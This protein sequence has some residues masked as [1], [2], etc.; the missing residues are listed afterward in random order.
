MI[1]DSSKPSASP[2]VG[3]NSG[4]LGQG[5]TLLDEPAIPDKYT[6]SDWVPA[7]GP[8]MGLLSV[9][10]VAVANELVGFLTLSLLLQLDITSSYVAPLVSRLF[11]IVL[12]L[13]EAQH[14]SHVIR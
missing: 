7:A 12:G 1:L 10:F 14:G 4:V 8:T 6:C 3:A 11:S 13:V 2:K 9:A 5:P